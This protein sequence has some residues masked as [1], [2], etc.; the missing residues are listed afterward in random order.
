MHKSFIPLFLILILLILLA[1][2][3]VKSQS[4]GWSVWTEP[5]IIDKVRPS[6]DPPVKN[7]SITLKG[8]KGEWLAFYVVMRGNENINNFVPSV[9]VTLTSGSNAIANG[10]WTFYMCQMV[11]TAGSTY[12]GQSPGDWPDPCVPYKDRFYGETRNG[13]AQGWNKTINANNTQ[14]F[15]FEIYIPSNAVA[16]MYAGTIRLSGTGSSSGPLMQDIPITLTVWN[17]SLPLQWSYGSYFGMDTDE[18]ATLYGSEGVGVELYTRSAADHGIWLY[19]QS[20]TYMAPTLVW[21]GG[22]YTGHVN[23][24]DPNFIG[25]YGYKKWLDGTAPN[26][27][28]GQSM[29][30]NPRPYYG[31]IPKAFTMRTYP[32]APF[33]SFGSDATKMHTFMDDWSTWI[34]TTHNYVVNTTFIEKATDEAQQTSGT[35]RNLPDNCNAGTYNTYTYNLNAMTG[36]YQSR[37]NMI[38]GPT[39]GGYLGAFPWTGSCTAFRDATFPVCW[40]VAEWLGFSRYADDGGPPFQPNAPRAN[41]S[42]RESSPGDTVWLYTANGQNGDWGRTYPATGDE[43]HLW[44]AW[45]IDIPLGF[46]GRVNAA[47][48][49]AMW[50]WNTS[51]YH[52]WA[53]TIGINDISWGTLTFYPNNPPYQVNGDGFIWYGGKTTGT[54]AIG[55]SHNIPIESLRMKLWRWGMNVL[56]Y[57]KLLE[58]AGKKSAADA[59]IA[60]M[61]APTTSSGTTWGTVAAWESARETMA[62][63]ILASSL[64]CST[65]INNNVVC[66]PPV[67]APALPPAGGK[68]IDPT[69]GTEIIRVTDRNDGNNAGVAY[70]YW[71]LFNVDS[72]KFIVF[73]DGTSYLYN[74]DKSTDKVTKVG[75]LFPQGSPI[76]SFEG[77]IWSAKDPD[78][79]YGF[80]VM[81]PKIYKFNVVT[82]NYTVIKDFSSIWPGTYIWQMSMDENDDVF[83][84]SVRRSSD[85]AELGTGWYRVSADTYGRQDWTINECQVD[86][87]GNYVSTFHG[88]ALNPTWTIWNILTDAKGTINWNSQEQPPGHY[89]QSYGRIFGASAWGAWSMKDLSS[90]QSYASVWNPGTSG[91]NWHVS[92]RNNDETYAYLS[93]LATD[94]LTNAA[95]ENEIIQVFLDGTGRYRRLAHHRSID[96]GAYS[97]YPK[98]AVDRLG[99][100]II[101]MSNWDNSSHNDVFILKIPAA[102]QAISFSRSDTNKDGCV[103]DTELFAF[104]DRWKVSNVDVTLKDLIEAIG[105]WKKGCS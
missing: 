13:A 17:F 93:N 78:I 61:Y 41:F 5:L 25:M 29:A 48:S 86:K 69:F 43:H 102:F 26:I 105:L 101:Y 30:Y 103:S 1:S 99:K 53:S 18:F 59:Q 44:S 74:F 85:Y 42:T 55:G 20:N 57:A 33:Y 64:A 60:K 82:K 11:I 36:G 91:L 98:A 95:L 21:S 75:Q 37:A 84:F 96:T 67:P 12:R 6:Y 31:Y 3:C 70:S 87:S 14:P 32:V 8:A 73:I 4:S 88:D 15:L 72:T 40:V 63:E 46:G 94:G 19:S 92:W 24:T 97:D 39:V 34:R 23:F 27:F 68:F 90:P 100:Y 10:N 62:N 9:Q 38:V 47:S 89:D 45:Y 22:D 35:D 83:A 76:L 49:L 71:N 28:P 7:T 54:Y 2:D 16:G 58:A 52:Y 77:M 81:I 66:P 51:G 65:E 104:I 80:V 50:A 56:E 79:L